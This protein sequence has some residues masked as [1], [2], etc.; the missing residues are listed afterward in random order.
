M[1]S[2]IKNFSAAFITY[3]MQWSLIEVDYSV[4]VLG[5]YH[6]LLKSLYDCLIT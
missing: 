1:N 4:L 5:K 2:G 3:I 6:A